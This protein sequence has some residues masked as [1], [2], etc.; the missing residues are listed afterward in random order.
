MYRELIIVIDAL[1]LPVARGYRDEIL[2]HFMEVG[3]TIVCSDQGFGHFRKDKGERV[4]D[5]SVYE[6]QQQ[7]CD[8]SVSRNAAVIIN[9]EM[10]SWKLL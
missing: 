9:S 8:K 2:W 4:D 1:I 10:N 5:L 3:N 6:L 7:I